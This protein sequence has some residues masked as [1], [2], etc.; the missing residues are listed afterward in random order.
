LQ[1]ATPFAAHNIAPAIHAGV[2]GLVYTICKSTNYP[3]YTYWFHLFA[4]LV[5]VV[6]NA[7]IDQDV[8]ALA[9]LKTLYPEVTFCSYKIFQHT[10]LL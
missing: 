2:P 3:G 10:S 8:P 7:A 4:T 9:E 6:L 1:S 5:T